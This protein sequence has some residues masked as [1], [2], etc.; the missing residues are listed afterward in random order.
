VSGSSVVANNVTSSGILV[1]GVINN[2]KTITVSSSVISTS[3][4]ADSITITQYNDFTEELTTENGAAE[5]KFITKVISIK[6]PASQIKMIVE[7]CVP[8]SADFD[9]YYKIGS[10]ATDFNTI[11]WNRFVAPNQPNTLSS[12]ATI[13]KSDVRN[14]FTDVEFNICGFDAAGNPVD[15]TQ[16]T[17]FQ[18]KMVMRS[19]NA[20]RVPQFRNLRVIAH[21]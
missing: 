10:S 12:Y 13:V 3:T 2:G 8:N 20:A 4:T 5:A 19:S 21:A 17:A 9:V 7:T 15:L 6:N 1:T 14:I 11:S 16:F 18:V